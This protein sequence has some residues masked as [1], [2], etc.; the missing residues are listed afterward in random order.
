MTVLTHIIN[1]VVFFIIFGWFTA[2]CS[3]GCLV[4]WTEECRTRPVKCNGSSWRGR[5]SSLPGLIEELARFGSHIEITKHFARSILRRMGFVKR[6]GRKAVKNLPSDFESTKSE[7]VEKLENDMR[8]FSVPHSLII[9][10]DQTGCQL[11]PCGGGPW[12]RGDL[13]K[14]LMLILTTNAK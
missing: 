12:K 5:R 6:K 1:W 13:N 10:W 11:V 14:F 8:E 2:Y 9:D 7:F 4:F 3:L